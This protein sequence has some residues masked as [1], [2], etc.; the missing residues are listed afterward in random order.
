M[1]GEVQFIPTGTGWARLI[2]KKEEKKRK[3]T[4]DK[5]KETLR[6]NLL[7][8]GAKSSPF[9]MLTES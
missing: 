8:L 9:K 2:V 4:M 3:E 5:W 1:G 6:I 7:A